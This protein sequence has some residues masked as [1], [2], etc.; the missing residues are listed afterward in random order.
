MLNIKPRKALE[1]EERM[2]VNDEKNEESGASSS[3]TISLK[4]IRSRVLNAKLS[5]FVHEINGND[6]LKQKM[7]A[8]NWGL[9]S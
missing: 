1:D 8:I 2:E 7:L 6:T 9:F 5:Q 4:E 3:N